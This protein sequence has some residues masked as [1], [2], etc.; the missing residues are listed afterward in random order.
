MSPEKEQELS[1][2]ILE[3]AQL[4]QMTRQLKL[5][6]SK[7][8]S[9]T[10]TTT[11]NNSSSTMSKEMSRKRSGDDIEI[12]HENTSLS[13][14]KKQQLQEG[15]IISKSPL[16][17][18]TTRTPPPAPPSSAAV[19]NSKTT[20]E[21]DD[22]Q[23]ENTKEDLEPPSTP[24]AHSQAVMLNSR[25]AN[26]TNNERIFMTPRRRLS[27]SLNK[28]NSGTNPENDA[29]ADLLMYLAT[30]PYTS[31]RQTL[32]EN[33]SMTNNNNNNNTNNTNIPYSR[34]GGA[35]IP[36]TPSS[37]Y[38]NRSDEAIRFSNMK[39][40]MSSPQSTFKVP[41][42]VTNNAAIAFSDVLMES[43]SL[44][45]ST[46]PQASSF[47]SPQK[48]RQSINNTHGNATLMPPSQQVP[49][50]PSRD[51]NNNGSGTQTGITSNHTLL[52]TPNFNMGDYIHNL[53]SP[54]PRVPL[55]GLR[56]SSI[57]GAI[58]GMNGTDTVYGTSTISAGTNISSNLS[59]NSAGSVEEKE[60]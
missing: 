47:L 59:S 22:S 7:V 56:R 8:T 39:P 12:K 18:A 9:N 54:S 46:S 57:T 36:S 6:L 26:A 16:K 1:N 23:E 58:L 3:R 35:K 55:S 51:N 30:S 24:R 19:S 25:N 31:V 48:R 28:R 20:N 27:T 21:D 49:T 40:S 42:M 5:G 14:T 33:M 17:F 13:P 52:K 44:Y 15:K 34:N 45:M 60:D 10:A 43:P 50:T 32:T 29:G 37:S 11:T 4:A 38:H 2:R 41:H 53:F